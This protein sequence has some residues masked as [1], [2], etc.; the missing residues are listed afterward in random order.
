MNVHRY[1]SRAAAAIA[2]AVLL[3]CTSTPADAAATANTTSASQTVSSGTWGAVATQ[4]GTAP[5]GSLSLSFG[6]NGTPGNPSFTS[7]YFTVQ[8]TGTLPLAAASYGGSTTAPST[9]QFAIEACSATWNADACPG[10]TVS[11]ILTAQGTSTIQ[12]TAGPVPATS[13]AVL[14]LRARVIPTGNVSK[15]ATLTLIIN[16]TVD[17]S[18]VRSATTTGG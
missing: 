13:A 6:N 3:V 4:S 1:S 7:E 11:T 5:Y 15:S 12:P 8:N 18:Q 10:G 17:R 16:I 2:A 9:A 14:T